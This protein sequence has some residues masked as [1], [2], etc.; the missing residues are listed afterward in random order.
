MEEKTIFEKIIDGEIP[1]AK[2]YE[3]DICMSILDKFPNTEG[4]V[5]VIPKKPVDYIFDLDNETYNH[6]FLI[7]KKIGSAL[8]KV[9]DPKRTCIVVEGFEV[10]HVHIKL[11]PVKNTSLSLSPGEEASDEDLAQLAEKLKKA[12]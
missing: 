12:L 6:I 11:Y 2:I 1:S 7:A 4:Q 3:D 8:D 10:P 9:I 5:L